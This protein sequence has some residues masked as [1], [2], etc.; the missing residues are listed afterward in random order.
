M[1]LMVKLAENSRLKFIRFILRKDAETQSDLL[2]FLYLL[3][4]RERSHPFYF[5]F[6]LEMFK[7]ELLWVIPMQ[8]LI[9][10]KDIFCWHIGACSTRIEAQPRPILQPRVLT[11]GKKRRKR[12][13]AVGS[14]HMSNAYISFEYVPGRW[15]LRRVMQQLIEIE[16]PVIEP[17]NRSAKAKRASPTLPTAASGAQY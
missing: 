10:S 3:S 6:L 1:L 12:W 14:I 8:L 15:P 7:S 13:R 9:V 11:R 16:Q 4:L 5:L 17:K 2:I